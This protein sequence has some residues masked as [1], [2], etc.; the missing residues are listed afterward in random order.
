[1]MNKLI[2]TQDKDIV[3]KVENAFTIWNRSHSN[4]QWNIIRP[5]LEK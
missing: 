1:M 4:Y 3:T 2:T 5:V